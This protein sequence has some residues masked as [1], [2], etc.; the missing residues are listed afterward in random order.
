MKI[1]LAGATGNLGRQIFQ[2]FWDRKME[3]VALAPDIEKLQSY[4][5]DSVTFHQVDVTCPESLRGVCQGI[6]LV[7]STIG[8][9]TVKSNLTNLAVDYQGNL[10]LLQEAQQSGVR[11]FI[12]ISVYGVDTDATV[13]MLDAKYRFEQALRKSGLN[14][15][16][17]RPTGYF[18]DFSMLFLPMAQKG[19]I[20]LMGKRQVKI[21]PVHPLD[22]AEWIADNLTLTGKIVEI[23]GPE[24]FTYLEIARLC[25]E[26]LEKQPRISVMP[27]WIMSGL[28]YL[29][30]PFAKLRSDI[31]RFSRWT[32]TT[33]FQAPHIGKRT[34]KEF[35][36]ES[37][38][39]V[40]R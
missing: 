34:L 29:L 13:P 35:L 19:T 18:T 32:M 10:N 7:I 33:P 36:R 3:F 39:R 4:Q 15:L 38:Q 30:R 25:F 9:T 14:W 26:L 20:Y 16:I 23:G 12:Y 22:L 40:E 21:N 11:N 17:I 31:L 24:D 27:V 28:I 5:R 6:D 37:L 8:L 2:V 1:L